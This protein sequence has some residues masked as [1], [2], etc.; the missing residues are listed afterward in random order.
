MV[1]LY[2]LLMHKDNQFFSINFQ[3]LIMI[4]FMIKGNGESVEKVLSK[5]A[6]CSQT[7]SATLGLRLMGNQ[8]GARFSFWFLSGAHISDRSFKT[9]SISLLF[10]VQFSALAD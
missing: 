6:K 1:I 5:S 9:R 2:Q 3:W 8:V 7:T 10:F 4:L